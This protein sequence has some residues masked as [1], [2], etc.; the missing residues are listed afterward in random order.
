MKIKSKPDTRT[1]VYHNDL[2][3]GKIIEGVELAE[4]LD[5]GWVK[6]PNELTVKPKAKELELSEDRVKKMKPEALVGLVQTLGYKVFTPKSLQIEINKNSSSLD[7]STIESEVMIAELEKRGAITVS[8]AEETKAGNEP[9]EKDLETLQEMF[10]EQPKSLTKPE[11]VKLGKEKYDLHLMVTW[12][13]VTL[14]SKIEDA[15]KG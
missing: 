1:W 7:I 13:E 2:P 3:E 4:H 5:E 6:K 14:I 12:K 15:I 9:E 10:N 11:L 8:G